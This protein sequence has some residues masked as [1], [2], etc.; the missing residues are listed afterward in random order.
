MTLTPIDD[1]CI[2]VQTP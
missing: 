2:L 1:T